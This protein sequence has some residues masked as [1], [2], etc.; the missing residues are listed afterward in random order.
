MRAGR[1]RV[2]LGLGGRSR[3]S[4]ERGTESREAREHDAGELFGVGAG[5]GIRGA[6]A[7][8][9]DDIRDAAERSTGEESGGDVVEHPECIRR[10]EDEDGGIEGER[11]IEVGR[12]VTERRQH[13]TRGFDERECPLRV[14]ALLLCDPVD[15]FVHL[16]RLPRATRC[17]MGRNR[18]GEGSEVPEVETA[19]ST[20]G[21]GVRWA[22]GV[23]LGP[24]GT[25]VRRL[26]ERRNSRLDGLEAE[27]GVPRSPERPR[28]QRSNE[29]LADARS[30]AQED[31]APFHPKTSVRA[32]TGL[33]CRDGELILKS[34]R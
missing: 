4:G 20:Q 29:G 34:P 6:R 16:D 9:H 5:R 26:D 18:I 28:Q 24:R 22:L 14:A 11:E 17:E 19:R 15:D 31:D 21:R 2:H 3:A 13:A 23:R 8:K 27:H 7:R 10:D 1:D 12:P 32:C 33:W 25:G 30:G